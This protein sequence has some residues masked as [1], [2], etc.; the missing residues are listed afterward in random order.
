MVPVT[1]L[2]EIPGL[3][4]ADQDTLA[5]LERAAV[6]YIE[7]ATSRYFGPPQIITEYVYGDHIGRLYL[8]HHPTVDPDYPQDGVEIMLGE[9]IIPGGAI[10]VYTQG[11]DY[12]VRVGDLES[13]VMRWGGYRWTRDYEY[14]VIYWRG[15]PEGEEPADIRQ[16]V[17][18][19]VQSGYTA[20]T[21]DDDLKSE[22]IGGYSYVRF[23]PGT[24]SAIAGAS[25]VIDYWRR[26]VF[27]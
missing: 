27:A 4:D 23:D 11:T 17:K 20:A 26:R 1:E 6:A 7:G 3:E 2:R 12:A 14:E 9:R 24:I 15:Y 19:M 16:L 22:T 25:A 13:V 21:G 18:D 10:T 8:R 5:A